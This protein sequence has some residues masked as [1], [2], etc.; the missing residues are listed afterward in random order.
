MLLLSSF[1]FGEP[2]VLYQEQCARCHDHNVLTAPSFTELEARRSERGVASLRQSLLEGRG[3]M[4][5]KGGCF[6]CSE[7]ELDALLVWMLE[8]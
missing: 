7:A 1:A 6:S 5:K 3:R 4:P 2:K 8:Q